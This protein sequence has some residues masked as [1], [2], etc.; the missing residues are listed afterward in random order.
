MADSPT[1]WYIEPMTLY[2]RHMHGIKSI[3]AS[4]RS[5]FQV[6]EMIDTFEYGKCLILDGKI[7]SS[8]L[9]EFIYHEALVHPAMIAHP[10]PKN[11][12]IIGGGEGATLREVLKY[13]SVEKVVM[14]EI[15][16][17][18]VK[19]SKEY[20]PSFN[21]GAFDDSRVELLYT[22]GRKYLEKSDTKFDVIIIDISEPLEDSPAYLL[23]TEEF[24]EIVKTHLTKDGIITTQMGPT[25]P[26]S[27]L[28]FVSVYMTLSRVFQEVVTYEVF[29]SCYATPWGFV[30]ASSL[31]NPNK[32][33]PHQID[34]SL[35]DRNIKELK[36]YDGETHNSIFSIGKHLRKALNSKQGKIIYDNEPLYI[37]KN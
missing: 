15:D 6:V 31:F 18:V 10:E 30:T 36:F 3:L 22:D 20:L 21:A 33:T 14:I 26:N 35:K 11:I 28:S 25:N 37:Y 1:T 9:D 27:L 5:K 12:L 23:F 4:K 17:E 34:E 2:R 13:K 32:L 16:E 8:E 24:Y 29:I 19:L 7:Q